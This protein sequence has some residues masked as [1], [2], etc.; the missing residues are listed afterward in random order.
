MPVNYLAAKAAHI[1]LTHDLAVRLAKKNVRVNC[2]SY[3]G[4]EGRVDEA[5][6]ERYAQMCP[7]GR[8]LNDS[9][10]AG[11]VMFLLSEAA[12]GVTGH[13][14]VADGGWSLW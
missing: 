4:I 3:G 11:P 12:S 8:M 9:D 2:I 13:N 6:K 14:L 1:H 10:L 5:F 7:S